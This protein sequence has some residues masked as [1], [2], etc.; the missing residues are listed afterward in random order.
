MPMP[1]KQL[2][3]S[4]RS[5]EEAQLALECGVDY[6]DLK[7]PSRGPLGRCDLEFINDVSKLLNSLPE[8]ERPVL[9]VAL[10]ELSDAREELINLVLPPM[11]NL[12][13]VGLSGYEHRADWQKQWHHKT[14]SISRA[15]SGLAQ[16]VLVA[17]ADHER[18]QSP[19][20]EEILATTFDTHA[21]HL[22][23]DTFSKDGTSL[24]NCATSSDLASWLNLASA[25]GLEFAIAGSLSMND[26]QWLDQ[27]NGSFIVGMRGGL[28]EHGQRVGNLSRERVESALDWA[29]KAQGMRSR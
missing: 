24:K 18:A 27:I 11:V 19:C 21:T 23:I 16:P 2:L 22:L 7:E 17:Y 28:C 20:V 26:L 13:K 29:R 15:S 5:I 6:L 12:F 25:A 3:V 1:S 4:V 10:G 9:S 14:T 8:D